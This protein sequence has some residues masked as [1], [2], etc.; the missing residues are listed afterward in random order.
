VNRN[1]TPTGR[2]HLRRVRIPGTVATPRFAAPQ[3]P[4]PAREH[5][6]TATQRPTERSCRPKAAA[7][8]RP[9]P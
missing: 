2:P 6:A 7:P 5:P 1:T 8:C 4:T 3:R 9:A